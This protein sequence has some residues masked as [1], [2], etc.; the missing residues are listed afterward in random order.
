[1]DI[2]SWLHRLFGGSR[3]GVPCAL[4]RCPIPPSDLEKGIA[5]VIARKEFCRGCVEEITHRRAQEGWTLS[6]DI[7]SSSTVHLL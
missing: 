3:R 7:G 5:L 4:C 6:A 1:M 2:G